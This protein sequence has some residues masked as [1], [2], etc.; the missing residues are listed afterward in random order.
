FAEASDFAQ[1]TELDLAVNEERITGLERQRR[2][3][4]EEERQLRERLVLIR[5]QAIDL[6]EQCH[7]ADETLD[8]DA[9]ALARLEAQVVTTQKNYEFDERRL[10]IAQ[11]ELIQVQARLGASQTDLGRQQKHL[12][13]RNRTLASRR[14]IIARS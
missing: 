5:Q 8:T 4:Q 10:H 6:E 1:K 12:G 14:E 2:Q 11:S 3:R 9:A 7:L 13:E